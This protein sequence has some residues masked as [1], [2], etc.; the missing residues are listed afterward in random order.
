MSGDGIGRC[1]R[2]TTAGESHGP[3]LV[4]IVEGCPPDLPV[5]EGYIQAALD[6]R[7]PGSSALVSQRRE[8]DRVEILSGVYQGRSTGAPIALLIRNEDARSRDYEALADRFRPGHADYS[9][10]RKYG[11]R[12]PYGGG[13][14]SARE[15]A[16]RVAAGAIAGRFLADRLGVRIHACLAQVGE[17]AFDTTGIRG[18]ADAPYAL[19]EAERAAE[20]E[21]LLETV[22]AERDSL[23]ALVEVIAEGLPPGLG[24]PVF[25]RLDADLAHALMS[26]H[27]VKGVEVGDGFGVVTQRGSEHRDAITPE[28]FGSNH[29]GGVLGGISTGQL[30][31]A[32][33]AFKPTSSI[34]Q[35]VASIDEQGRPV[36]VTVKGRHDPCVG[37]RGVPVV[38]AMTAIVLADHALRQRA[39]NA[40]VAHSFPAVPPGED[41]GTDQ[42]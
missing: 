15:T 33:V 18:A 4:A 6:R 9:V 30:L 24:E 3:A 8:A 1:F 38:A 5:E 21:G 27:A 10:Q 39:Q 19:P 35:P 28:G 42:G 34:P 11:R 26:I 7:R 23:G 25:D 32:R 22:R 16:L 12:D 13:R 14:S 20:L 37:I 36:E 29:A 40:E 31:R 2:V 17:L 41:Q